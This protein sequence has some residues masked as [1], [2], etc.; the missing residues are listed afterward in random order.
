ME[1]HAA[2][3]TAGWDVE[4]V[5]EASHIA[6]ILWVFHHSKLCL[7]SISSVASSC[8]ITYICPSKWLI[9]DVCHRAGPP[10][11]IQSWF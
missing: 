11:L 8:T 1:P 9:L 4:S 6:W 5:R 10:I 7:S 3:G 2:A